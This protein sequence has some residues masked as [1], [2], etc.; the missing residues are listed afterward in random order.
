[1]LLRSIR[2]LAGLLFSSIL[3]IG[4]AG[5]ASGTGSGGKPMGVSTN[6]AAL[7]AMNWTLAGI[8]RGK[9]AASGQLQAGIP[10]SRYGLSFTQDGVQLLGGCNV[11]GSQFTLAAADKIS[12]GLWRATKRACQQ[13]LMQADSEVLALL[14]AV[15]DYQVTGQ[16]LTL[17]GGGNTLSFNGKATDASRY[18]SEGVRRFIDVK[19]TA[20]GLLWREAKYDSHWIRINKDAPWTT[21]NF[22]GI[23]NFSAEP[24]M[25]Y[26]VRIKEY[27]D[28]ATGKAVWVKDL[29]TMQGIPEG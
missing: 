22:P 7:T 17:S 13:P 11:A 20:Q 16:Q 1:M 21:G 10:A 18:G 25:E 6:S 4:C 3:L 8:Q 27:R 14:S 28:P 29:V 5:A 12:F 15:T 19:N 9:G 24:G 23:Q 2:V 26:T